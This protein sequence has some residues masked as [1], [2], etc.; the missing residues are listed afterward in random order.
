M[1]VTV[2]VTVFVPMLAQSKLV[3]LRLRPPRPEA[4][5]LPLLTCSGV[6]LPWPVASNWSVRFWQTATGGTESITVTVEV[7]V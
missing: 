5:V 7:P 2:R 6:M 1:S 4:S 3:W